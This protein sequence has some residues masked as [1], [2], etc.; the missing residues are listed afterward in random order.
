MKNH[1]HTL[2]NT[3]KNN[4]W[5]KHTPLEHRTH[6]MTTNLILPKSKH[7]LSAKLTNQP[8]GTFYVE[9]TFDKKLQATITLPRV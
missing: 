5:T 9:E 7:E 4:I 8:N 2:D 6:I 3:R 1:N